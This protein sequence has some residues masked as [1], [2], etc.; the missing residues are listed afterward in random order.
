MA[1]GADSA[2]IN[3]LM[4]ETKTRGRLNVDRLMLETMQ[5]HFDGRCALIYLE[6]NLAERFGVTEEELDGVSSLPRTVEG[7]LAGITI[8]QRENDTYRISLRTQA[9]VDASKI[10]AAFGGGGHAAAAGCTLIGSLDAVR[11]K[12]LDAVKKELLDKNAWT[13]YSV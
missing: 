7:V 8:R 11:D 9:P 10:C 6:M 5:F 12:I 4:F 13:E 2:F 1:A 3:K